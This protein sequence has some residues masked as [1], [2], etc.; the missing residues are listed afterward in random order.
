MR[1]SHS[2][3]ETSVGLFAFLDV[4]MSTMGSLILVLMIVSPKIRQEKMAKAAT[5]AA[6]DIVKVEPAPT[7]A[8]A[9][10]VAP[11]RETIDL[12][13]KFAT[14]VS[15][16]SGQA[17]DKRR[18]ADEKQR[19]LTTE[20]ERA[21]KIRAEREQLERELAQLRATKDTTLASVQDLSAEGL[22]VE[23]ELSKRGSRLRKIQDQI[24]HES[25]EYSFVAYD[26]VS[27]TTRRPILIE[28]ADDQIKFPQENI[29]LT[30]ADISGFTTSTNPVR[31]GAEALLE[32]WST[33][34]KPDDPKPYV[35]IVVRPSGTLA[36]Y[37]ARNLLQRMNTPF[38]YELLSEDQK[39]AV[40]TPDQ[41]A[42]TAC[43]QAVDQAIAKRDSVF[44]SVFA[45]RGGL[46]SRNPW[47]R[48]AGGSRSDVTGASGTGNGG[49]PNSPFDDPFDLTSDGT[50]G[51][52]AKN[53][54]KGVDGNALVA[55]GN[56]MA[57]GTAPGAAGAGGPAM[58][59]GDTAGGGPGGSGSGNGSASGGVSP[60]GTGSGGVGPGGINS[61]KAG[62]AGPGSGSIGSG[63]MAPGAFRS[64]SNALASGGGVGGPGD[65]VG[66]GTAGAGSA[67]GG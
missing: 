46:S 52:G 21:N 8:P 19:N 15:E 31:A 38:G 13:A 23:S 65:L 60:G 47:R 39:L 17:D 67:T 41:A 64:G 6:R 61:G 18:T 26:G 12:N 59:G 43:R 9:P 7:P 44:D 32:Y 5:E 63:G 62:S 49:S 22:R 50:K 33:H 45:N 20:R 48:G 42:V 4:L 29:T 10:V 11:P 28:C 40:P 14:R 3:S 51:N 53:T 35:L 36:Y 24:A 2:V 34:S 1:R 55:S 37:R 66:G 54:G 57:G 30:S 25:T 58:G 27:G 56:T 16:L